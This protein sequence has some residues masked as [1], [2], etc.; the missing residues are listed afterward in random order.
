MSTKATFGMLLYLER[1]AWRGSIPAFPV[2][3]NHVEAWRKIKI[4]HTPFFLRIVGPS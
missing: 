4:T 2:F 3:I 1:D